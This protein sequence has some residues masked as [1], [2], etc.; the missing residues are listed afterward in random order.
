MKTIIAAL[1]GAL[2]LGSGA[3]NAQTA[4]AAHEQHQ[5]AAPQAGPKEGCCCEKQMTEMM[6]MMH[7]MMKAHQAMGMQPGMKMPMQT[8]PPEA[9]DEHKH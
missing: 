9:T 6:S 7:E 4:P 3:A 1:G 5:H 8:K 2:L